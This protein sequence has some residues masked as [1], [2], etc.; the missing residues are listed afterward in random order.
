[1]R[2]K[3][4]LWQWLPPLMCL[5]AFF[6]LFA[7]VNFHYMPRLIDGDIYADMELAREI[8]RKKALFPDNWV[9]GN[10]YYTVAT[11]V[12]AALFYGLTG[13]MNLSMALATTLMSLLLLGSLWWMLRPFVENRGRLLAAIL[14]FVACPMAGD[15][16]R[17]PQGQLFFTLASYYACYLITLC[18]VF[19]DYARAALDPE[20]GFRPLPFA[21]ALAL[22]FLTGMQSLRQTLIMALPILAVEALRLL[23]RRSNRRTLIRALACAAANG[24]GW[25][26]MKLLRVPARTIY[27]QVELGG[28]GIGARLL[29]DWHAVR[30]VTG[31][32]T[33]LFDGPRAF[34][35][36][37]FALTVLLVPAAALLLWKKRRE[38]SGV[39]LLW[40]LTAVSLLGTLLAGIVVEIRMRE[41]YLFLW[42]L[43]VGLSLIPVL[44]ALGE[45]GRRWAIPVLCL[46]CLGNLVCS[47]GSSLKLAEERDP[48]PALA[49]CRDAEAAGIEYVYGD[50]QTT[51]ALLVWSDGRITGGFWDEIIFLVRDNINLQDIY[52]EEHNERALYVL[53]PWG[54]ENFM[55]YCHE[56]GAE[57]EVFG[58]YGDWIAYRATKQLMNFGEEP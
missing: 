27:G 23:L 13:S 57:Y 33:A 9:Y 1:M 4:A 25:G 52:G 28:G 19:G 42:Y 22:S 47:Y 17:E 55:F 10:Q 20:K 24:L 35:L 16:L 45:K 49:F 31:L 48:A 6:G 2:N 39:A 15:I 54:R 18:L 8:W 12:A 36:V 14:L 51:P 29:A 11:P 40:A 37:F 44:E 58:E 30:G 38:K 41:I 50:W 7:L 46:L 26:L 32:D 43:L 5:A 3:S 21:L 34:Y 53:G 56:M